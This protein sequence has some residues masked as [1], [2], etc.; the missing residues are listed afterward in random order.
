ME[1]TNIW[2]MLNE[3]KEVIITKLALTRQNLYS[4]EKNNIYRY[5]NKLA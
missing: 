4:G 3:Q 2:Y 1:K 5:K